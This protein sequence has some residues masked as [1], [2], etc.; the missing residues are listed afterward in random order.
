MN[1]KTK[2]LLG[3]MALMLITLICAAFSFSSV[4]DY[5]LAKQEI[6]LRKIGHEVLLHSGDSTSRVLPV[7]KIAANEYQVTFENE[8]TFQPDSLVNI[9][10]RSLLKNQ[11][12]QDYIVNVLNC[13]G[14]SV[15]FGYAISR[16]EKSNIIACSG[17]KQP[18]SCYII[19]IK[20]QDVA[21]ITPVQK[22]YLIGSSIPLLAFVGLLLFR[23]AKTRNRNEVT[24]DATEPELKIGNTLLNVQKRQL[25]TGQVTTA[26]TAKECKLLLIFAQSPNITIER[27]RL[28]KEIWED[29]GV[30]VGRSL[31]MFISKLRKKLESDTA[32]QLVNIHGTGYKLKISD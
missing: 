28:Q 25:I 22:G 27:S 13:Q 29:E 24:A 32:L 7:R 15:L 11:L 20:F 10:K 18:K 5:D 14:N 4:D 12:A 6:I 1:T 21:G 23:S 16:D 9:I 31:D 17:R 26:L 19:D 8:F 3:L 2:Y 30:I